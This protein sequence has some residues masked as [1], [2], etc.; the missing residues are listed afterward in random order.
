M[1]GGLSSIES[2][3]WGLVTGV[4]GLFLVLFLTHTFLNYN[5]HALPTGLVGNNQV[6]RWLYTLLILPGVILHELSHAV[7]A[8]VLLVNVYDFHIGP[9]VVKGGLWLG[10][11]KHEK[12]DFLRSSI[13]GLAP[14]ISGTGAIYAISY[15]AFG[16]A[17]IHDMLATGNWL[18]AIGASLSTGLA[19][20]WGWLAVYFI[21]AVSASMFP[22]RPDRQ[23]WL[24][25]AL[26][27]LLILA[28]GTAAGVTGPLVEWLAEPI[29][30]MFR[31]LLFTYGLTIVIDLPI[32][33]LLAAGV[34]AVTKQ[35]RNI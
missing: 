28:V 5:A 32:L 34:R 18:E 23:S 21:F 35:P 15:F 12:T 27:L 17:H 29:N 24:P 6:A 31:W 22:S 1:A 19:N 9:K 8:L 16:A 7:T 13:I 25:A 2:I 30:T 4:G 14:L 10:Y 11:I 20:G 33:L 3:D 26:F